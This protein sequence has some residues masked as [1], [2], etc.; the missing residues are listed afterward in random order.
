MLKIVSGRLHEPH[1]RAQNWEEFT[2]AAAGHS[3]S[4]PEITQWMRGVDSLRIS[5]GCTR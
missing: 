5:K 1:D 2:E 4:F 3:M